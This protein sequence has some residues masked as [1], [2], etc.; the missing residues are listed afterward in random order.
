M[1]KVKRFSSEGK[2]SKSSNKK[3]NLATGLATG[4]TYLMTRNKDNKK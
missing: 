3:G 2:E 1:Y 4:A